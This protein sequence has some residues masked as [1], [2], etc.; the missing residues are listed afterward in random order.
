MLVAA[1]LTDEEGEIYLVGAT[2]H[3][4]GNTKELNVMNYKQAMLTID[5]KEWDQ[6][7]KM[8]HDKMVKYN[9]F[10]VVHT[11]DVPKGA[12][13]MDSTW[14]MKKKPDGTFRAIN[15]IRG[16]MQVDGKHYDSH[17]KSSPVATEVGIRIVFVL[18][19]LAGWYQHLVDVEGAFL[20][21]VFAKPDKHKIYMQV[22]EAY[23]AWYPSWAVFRLLKTQ[24]GTV[25][26]ALQYYREC[27]KALAFLNFD[28]NAA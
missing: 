12:R 22:P 4:Y 24:Y 8:E 14:A 18:T 19:L 28:R 7:V 5:K 3:N 11:K 26:A 17:D 16:F 15:A 27:F 25:Q 6:A 1:T 21:G 23:K 9:V 20:N 10:E 2:C 13:L